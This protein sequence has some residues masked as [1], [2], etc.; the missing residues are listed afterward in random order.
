MDFKN[1]IVQSWNNT[2]NFIGPV[3]LVTL[4]QLILIFISLGTLAPVTT[5]GY[6][7]SLL[8]AVREGRSPE[9][10]DLFS[11]MRLFLPLFLFY[12]LAFLVAMIGFMMVIIP[13]FVV[14]GFVAF[15]SF[16]MLPLMT[17]QKFGLFEALQRSWKLVTAPPISDHLIIAII[18]VIIMSLGSSLPFA[19]L[20]TQPMA[21][22]LMIGAY[23]ENA[24]PERLDQDENAEGVGIKRSTET[25]PEETV[26]DEREQE[27][28]EDK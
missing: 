18:Y 15:A 11:Q 20:V 8:R 26:H 23:L 14:I 21:T 22:F 25:Q 17:D 9:V 28:S 2:L 10:G 3:L 13:G 6:V 1:L 5:A 19:F 12:L 24:A 16:Y 4:V 7:Q 27:K